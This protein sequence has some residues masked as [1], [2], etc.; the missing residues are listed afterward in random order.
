[1]NQDTV[2]ELPPVKRIFMGI[3]AVKAYTRTVGTILALTVS[4]LKSGRCS[5]L[6]ISPLDFQGGNALR[7]DCVC[8]FLSSTVKCTTVGL[9][10]NLTFPAPPATKHPGGMSN[11]RY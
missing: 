3:I 10:N 7:R 5:Q 2:K 8:E 11:N 6:G 9:T 1:M 4:L